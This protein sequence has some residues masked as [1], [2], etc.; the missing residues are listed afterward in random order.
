MP[1]TWTC[2]ATNRVFPTGARPSPKQ[3]L[4]SAP[5][6]LPTATPPEHVAYVPKWRSMLGND[7]YGDCVT[8]EEGFAKTCVNPEKFD[9]Q[10]AMDQLEQV[11]ISYARA[12]GTLHGAS[13]T[14]V[15]DSMYE[16]GFQIG[17]QLYNDGQK[18][19]VDYTNETILKAAIAQGPVKLAMGAGALP[20]GAGS[21]DGWYALSSRNY[22][23]DHSTTLC[24]YGTV[25][26]CYDALKLPVPSAIPAGT[27]GYLHYTWSTIGFVTQA[28]VNGAC[29]EAWLRTPTTVGIPPLAPPVPPPP[30]TPPEIKGTLYGK[31]VN[32]T[33]VIDG[34]VV[35][36]SATIPYIVV[37][38]GGGFYKFVPKEVL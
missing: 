32:G 27:H 3:A 33:V 26:F 12:H 10:A 15:L 2:P 21:R 23:S 8:A 18:S 22:S 19:G 38:I 37:P 1:A 30:P 7:T 31:V 29:D 28:W 14:E 24:G 9:S 13:L 20:G 16:K 35:I 5:T 34:E 17:S 25:E 6:F 4:L 11:V 36:P